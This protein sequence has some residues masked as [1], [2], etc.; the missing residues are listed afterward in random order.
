MSAMAGPTRAGTIPEGALLPV[1]AGRMPSSRR[2]AA[3]IGTL[4]LAAIAALAALVLTTASSPK[5]Q[6]SRARSRPREPEGMLAPALPT[7][8]AAAASARIGAAERSF[9]PVRRGATLLASGG[10]IH[11]AF[12]PAHAIL[13]VRD[14]TVALSLAAV[15]RGSHLQRVGAAA[16]S[17]STNEILYSHRSIGEQFRNGP[18]GLEQ[19]FTVRRRPSPGAGP[20]VLALGLGGS[21]V[22]H[23]VGSQVQFETRAG[24]TA[25]RYGQLGATDATGRAVPARMELRGGALELLIDDR[26]ARYPIHIDPFVQAGTKFTDTEKTDEA[27]FGM[28]VALSGDGNTALIGGKEAAWVFVREGSAWKQQDKL[29]ASGEA[30]DGYSVALSA[31]GNTA[32][33]GVEEASSLGAAFVFVREG[34]TWKPQGEKLTGKGEVGAGAFGSSVALS[35][36]GATAL[37]GARNNEHEVGK[38]RGA[39]WVFT[40]TGSTWE[41]QTEFTDSEKVKEASLGSSIALSSEGTT[42]LVGAERYKGSE[43]AAWVFTGSGASWTQQEKLTG[44]SGVGAF[45]HSVALSANGDTALVGADHNGGNDAGAAWVFIREGSKWKVPGTKLPNKLENGEDFGDS[46]ALSGEGNTA[47]VGGESNNSGEGAAWAFTREGATWTEQTPKLTGKEETGEEG[48]AFGAGV[49]LSASGGIALIGGP[50]DEGTNDGKN[51]KG[52]AWVFATPPVLVTEG[53]SAVSQSAATVT[54]T[55]NPNGAEVTKCEFEYGTSEALGSTA[56]CAS[57]PGSGTTAAAVSASISGLQPETTY[58]YRLTASNLAG[59]GQGQEQTFKTLPVFITPP[60]SVAFTITPNSDPLISLKTY[61]FAITNPEPGVTYQWD[62]GDKDSPLDSA[63]APFVVEATGTSVTYA[64]PSPP[65]LDEAADGSLCPGSQ[66]G[67]GSPFAVY[68]VRAQA[69]VPQ[70]GTP[71][72]A[73]P[74]RVVVIPVQRPTAH[75]QLLR[76][77]KNNEGTGTTTVVTKP[78]TIVP[79]AAINESDANAGDRIVREDFWLNSQDAGPPDLTCLS[80]GVC[81]R[82]DGSAPLTPSTVPSPDELEQIPG[83]GNDG[84]GELTQFGTPVPSVLT[85]LDEFGGCALALHGGDTCSSYK[86][87]YSSPTDGFESFSINFWN[88][89]L[90]AIG[91]SASPIP[92][93]PPEAS[94]PKSPGFYERLPATIGYPPLTSVNLAQANGIDGEQGTG[95]SYLCDPSYNLGTALFGG[96]EIG[97]A[98]LCVGSCF[99]GYPLGGG[100]GFPV[101]PECYSGGE[102]N[103]EN[104]GDNLVCLEGQG[105][106]FF[107]RDLGQLGPGSPQ[108]HE[109]EWNFLYNYAT[110]VGVDTSLDWPDGPATGERETLTSKT[111]VPRA[112]TMVAYDAEGVASEPAT[113]SVPLTPATNP[114]LDVCVEDVTAGSPCVQT[115]EK[116]PLPFPI[117]EKDTLRFKT[118]GSNGGSDPIAYYGTAVGQPNYKEECES[119]GAPYFEPSTERPGGLRETHVPVGEGPL[120]VH[121]GPTPEHASL[122][123]RRAAS[124]AKPGGGVAINPVDEL[125]TG[126][127]AIPFPIPVFSDLLSGAFPYHECAAYAQRTVNANAKPPALPSGGPNEPAHIASLHSRERVRAHE[128]SADPLP[129]VQVSAGA[130]AAANGL[131]FEFPREGKYSVSV[132]AY[133]TS[134]LGA[135]TRIDGFEATKAV[136]DGPCEAVNSIPVRIRDPNDKDH[137]VNLGFSGECV[138]IVT[139]TTSAHNGEGHPLLYASKTTIDID[140]VPLRAQ[141]GDAIVIRPIGRE[142]KN[143]AEIYVAPCKFSAFETSSSTANGYCPQKNLGTIY[144]AIGGGQNQSPP[145]IGAQGGFSSTKARQTFGPLPGGTRMGPCGELPGSKPWAIAKESGGK[146]AGFQGF[147]V[148]SEPC[149]EFTTSDESHLEFLDSLPEEFFRHGKAATSLIRMEGKDVPVVSLLETNSYANVARRHRSE[150]VIDGSQSTVS[151]RHLRVKGHAAEIGFPPV[152]NCNPAKHNPNELEVPQ[153]DEVGPIEMPIGV[154]FCYDKE[155]GDYTGNV[156]VNIPAPAVFPLEGVEVGFEIGHGRLIDAGGEIKGNVPIGPVFLNELKFDIQTD[157]TVVA[158]AIEASIADIIGVE[159]AT[160]VK[161]QTPEVAIEGTVILPIGGIRLG[162]FELVIEKNITKLRVDIDEQFGPAELELAVQGAMEFDPEFAFFME[163]SGKACL[164]I[165]LGAKGIVSNIGLAAC[166]EINLLFVTVSAGVGVL[167]SGPNSGVHVFTGCDLNGYRPPS[168][169][170]VTFARELPAVRTSGATSG[171]PPGATAPTGAGP[172]AHAAGA[173]PQAVLEA[174]GHETLTLNAGNL[175]TPKDETGCTKGAVAVQVHSLES[176]AGV[177]NVPEVTLTGPGPEDPRVITTPGTPDEFGYTPAGTDLTPPG[178]ANEGSAFVDPDP[179]PLYDQVEGSSAYCT[180]GEHTTLTSLPGTCPKVVTT[181]IFVADPGKGE[182]TLSVDQGSP[183]VVD[184]SVAQPEPPVSASEFNPTVRPVTLSTSFHGVLAHLSATTKRLELPATTNHLDTLIGHHHL[185]LSPS[186][187]I[188]PKTPQ[189][190]TQLEHPSA[191]DLDVPSIDMGLLRAVQL[192]VPGKWKG[193]VAIIDE[194][195]SGEQVLAS[196]I[197]TSMIPS[198]GLPVLFKPVTGFGATHTIKAFLSNEEGIPSQT[199]TLSTYAAPALP[200]PSPPT[201][202]KIVR[203]G[204]TVDVFFNP[205]GAFVKEGIGLALEAG[206]GMVI[207]G[208][209]TFARLHAVGKRRGL[210]AAG[211]AGEYMLSITHVDPTVSINLAIDDSVAGQV[212]ATARRILGPAIHPVSELELLSREHTLRPAHHRRH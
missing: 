151:T 121:H 12:T 87:Q 92:T 76:A 169:R 13:R 156:K 129:P 67:N 134:G 91:S 35:G 34:S 103:K 160:V 204:S 42:A 201:I 14:G 39:V 178:P 62:F 96:A 130:S 192:K 69:V 157:P 125:I 165:C 199:L 23:Q 123:A 210:G 196:H 111:L 75:F 77:Q 183:P 63:S 94:N 172:T 48:D 171:S 3:L 56:P 90:A 133:N 25:L 79:Q 212:S 73:T 195:P 170:N 159:A 101:A 44:E 5:V 60:S 141:Q 27:D 119:G 41:Y 38:E 37:V 120:E 203:H 139:A 209:V 30:P 40:R 107:P 176:Q 102:P 19:G 81:G 174:G 29:P 140:G 194:S 131:P 89:A 7:N 97:K 110:V 180:E 106:G 2:S 50:A 95:D 150:R 175:C 51:H 53:S 166:G 47:I 132:A 137:E 115:G 211:Q 144:L 100:R 104:C 187:E 80:D 71:V 59:A 173:T 126:V 152:P 147:T 118:T 142:N 198:G 113:Q 149:V 49:S 138:S 88:A 179:V 68:L 112:V 202:D 114:T 65:V 66:C 143:E 18:Y 99:T 182:W 84:T 167:W 32:I 93:L 177:G 58:H 153:G 162:G 154:H 189:I 186:V 197:S 21:L 128:A 83:L 45:G 4:A 1:G 164:W 24:A 54:G 191:A 108:H 184:V 28:H 136:K 36:N 109:D 72:S 185:L 200:T 20:L 193:T 146:A 78:V 181:T 148:A 74:Q 145:G 163:G 6:G 31:N 206:N 64:Y 155:T 158:G 22:A 10:G 16:P 70:G 17:S 127:K 117:T 11:S 205:H 8:L 188:P 46:V 15:G 207:Q 116:K 61:T 43:G 33:V 135:I 82:Y 161:P 168:L 105:T 208:R 85:Q 122:R 124:L 55:V 86:E 190:R 9:W 26:G 57:A 98:G 52:A